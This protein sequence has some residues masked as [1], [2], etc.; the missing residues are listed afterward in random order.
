MQPKKLCLKIRFLECH[1]NFLDKSG[2][3]V[4]R[5]TPINLSIIFSNGTKSIK[6]LLAAF[7]TWYCFQKVLVPN[8]GSSGSKNRD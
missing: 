3:T 4:S 1:G 8:T 7:G 6:Y 5:A 2:V